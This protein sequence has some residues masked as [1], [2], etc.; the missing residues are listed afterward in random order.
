MVRGV[1]HDP[2]SLILA[3]AAAAD[4]KGAAVP[5]ELEQ[6]WECMRYNALPN[7]GG[8]R[9]Q[10]AGLIRRMTTASFYYDAMRLQLRLSSDAF[11]AHHPDHFAAWRA[12]TE[13]RLKGHT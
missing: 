2:F 6:A 9:D 12:V 3:A 11:R 7:P 4:T 5:P 1:D 13:L 8:L 10:P